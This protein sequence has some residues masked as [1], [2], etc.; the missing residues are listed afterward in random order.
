MSRRRKRDLFVA[1]LVTVVTLFCIGAV[2]DSEFH[3][4]R[5]E[6]GLLAALDDYL[7]E[8]DGSTVRGIAEG[9]ELRVIAHETEGKYLYVF[10]AAEDA[11]HVHGILTMV[12]GINGKYRPLRASYE[13]FPYTAGIYTGS[14]GQGKNEARYRVIGG[15]RCLGIDSVRI[16]YA[17]WS[18]EDLEDSSRAELTFE[19][20]D[21]DFLWLIEESEFKKELGLGEDD[22]I[23]SASRISLF[24]AAGND[25]TEKYRDNSVED[26]WGTGVGTAETEL[27]YVL[28]GVIAALGI[29]FVRFFLLGSREE[30]RE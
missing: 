7:L 9:T 3:Y 5:T 21:H 1:V 26:S 25:I 18:P 24:D 15:D 19:L 10:F 29:V 4:A 8:T 20:L 30:E 17:V 22:V 6:A 16:E 2:Y 27:L 14:V 23:M 11:D 13:P 28:I 12:R